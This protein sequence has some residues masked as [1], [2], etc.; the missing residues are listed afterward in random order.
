MITIYQPPRVWGLPC[1]SPFCSKLETYLKM[2]GIPYKTKLSDFRS[3]PN[4]RIPYAEIDGEIV[5]DSS[6]IIGRLKSLYG[7]SL[8]QDLT[9]E[10]QATSLV[11][12]RLFEDHLFRAVAWLRW[13]EEPSWHYVKGAL[14]PFMP[15]VVGG[16][17]LKYV[18]KS[19]INELQMEPYSHEEI[20]ELA[21]KDLEA[22][23]QLL[24]DRPFV[25]GAK[26]HTIDATVYGFL[27]QLLD[28]PWES[29]VKTYATGLKNLSSYCER[30]KARF[31]ATTP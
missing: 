5:G 12:Q 13:S 18:R 15:P 17:I 31:W 14:A 3:A 30:M 8:D 10:Q 20:I 6:R 16:M 4:G 28:V 21:K 23:S 19:F 2:T 9:Q 7:D 11:I 1:M 25:L 22:F 26:P 27:I 24:G 29:E